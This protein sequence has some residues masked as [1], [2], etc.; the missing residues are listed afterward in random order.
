M[1]KFKAYLIPFVILVL[2]FLLRVSL[3]SAGPYHTDCLAL[4]INAQNTLA[5]HQI[6]YQFGSGYILTVLGGSFFVGLGKMLG[7]HDPVVCVNFMSAVFSS[8]TVFVLYFVVKKLADS[9][10]ALLSGILFSLSPI[11]LSVSVYGNSHTVSIF[12]LVLGIFFFCKYSGTSLQRYFIL[13]AL[14]IG[15]MATARLQDMILMII[16]LSALISSAMTTRRLN[17]FFKNLF[18]FFSIAF[19]TTLTI[20]LFLFLENNFSQFFNQFSVFWKLGLKDNFRGIISGSLN[21]SFSYLSESFSLLGLITGYLGFYLLLKNKPK[22]FVFLFIWFLIPL[23]FYG[24]LHTTA[25]RFLNLIL[26]PF[27][28]AIGYLFSQICKINPRFR[29]TGL[30]IF[31]IM[32]FFPFRNIY[33]VVAFRHTYNLLP[34]FLKW[35]ATKTEKNALIISGD[36]DIFIRYYAGRSSFPR[37]LDQFFLKDILLE[38]FKQKLNKLLEKNTPVYIISTGLF[39]YDPGL[40][41][42]SYIKANYKLIFLGKRWSEDWHRGELVLHTGPMA[43]FRVVKKTE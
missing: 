35:M 23:L 43:L 29:V 19:L 3:L 7:I 42:S 38:E 30:A 37:P 31:L 27:I 2:S 36:E 4:A 15:L 25:P 9:M 8:L 16:P 5:S 24:N 39:A 14:S 33:P 40:K 34:D 18:W 10:A 20:Y 26:P 12:F 1:Q 11:F 21:R 17:L 41:F 28:A 22:I 6:H 13:S 32:L